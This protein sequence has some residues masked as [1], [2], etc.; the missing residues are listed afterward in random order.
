MAGRVGRMAG[1]KKKSAEKSCRHDELVLNVSFHGDTRSC[2]LDLNRSEHLDKDRTEHIIQFNFWSSMT[3]L[4]NCGELC[5]CTEMS[6]YR[7]APFTTSLLLHNRL[8]TSTWCNVP[9]RIRR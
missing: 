7:R 2:E 8:H 1:N 9:S 4:K 6:S 3:A 5:T